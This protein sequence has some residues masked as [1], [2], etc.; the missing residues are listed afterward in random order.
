MNINENLIEEAV[1][2]KTKALVPVHYAGVSCEMEQIMKIAEINKL[3]VIEDAAQAVMST[4]NGKNL[5]SVGDI[6]CYSF[7]ETKNYTMGEGGAIAIQNPLFLERSEIIREKGTNRS[8]FLRGMVDKYS[9]VDIGSSYLPSDLNAAYLYAQL[10]EANDINNNRLEAW[11]L[12]FSTLENLQESGAVTL[13]F[14]PENCK[15]NAHMFYIKTKNLDERTR[16]IEF[17][18]QRGINAVFHYVPLHSSKSGKEFGRFCGIDK[19]TSSESNKLIRLPMYH[20]I[21]Q[22]DII[23]IS[24]AIYSFY[25]NR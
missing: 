14:V 3:Y 18:K 16:L 22:D 5:G 1:T 24:E 23:K 13:P 17:L 8:Q 7:H 2:A 11:N 25:K 10:E 4:Y 9:W 20:G 19:Y 21:K 15:H 6:G 12:Y